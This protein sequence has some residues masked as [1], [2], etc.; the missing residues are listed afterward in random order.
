LIQQYV[1]LSGQFIVQIDQ[2]KIIKTHVS[3]AN[4]P[5][6]RRMIAGRRQRLQVQLQIMSV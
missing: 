6:L 2:Q 1:T 5:G 4:N 3:V